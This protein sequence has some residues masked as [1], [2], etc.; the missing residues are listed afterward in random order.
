LTLYKRIS[1]ASDS[2]GLK[3]LQSEL[4]DRFGLLPEPA[5]NLFRIHELK[6]TTEPLGIRKLESGSQSGRIVFHG[7]P[8]VDPDRIIQLIQR[9][10]QR[11]RLEGQ[12]TLR[13][14][15]TDQV[16]ETDRI[17]AVHRLVDELTRPAAP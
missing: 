8:A 3:A 14:R 13:F 9:D 10:P 11:W 12:D 7:T 16:A 17:A 2:E 5:K 4:I 1:A 15:F 6:L